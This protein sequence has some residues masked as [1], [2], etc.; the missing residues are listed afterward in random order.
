MVVPLDSS[1]IGLQLSVNQ[2]EAIEIRSIMNLSL[3]FDHRIMDGADASSFLH[4]V[5]KSM[6]SFDEDTTLE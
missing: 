2:Q 4:S 6:E 5:K 1:R 3:S